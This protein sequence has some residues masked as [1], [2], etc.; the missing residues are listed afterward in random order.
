MTEAENREVHPAAELDVAVPPG[1]VLKELLQEAGTTV[2]E[3]ADTTG[4]SVKR[5]DDL[6]A[7]TVELCHHDAIRLAQA[8]GMSER[9][10]ARMEANY[11][12]DLAAGKP[13]LQ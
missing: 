3:L 2:A 10:W 12:A 5:I 4:L 8:A 9:L 13:V 11:R 6:I 1:T 7:G